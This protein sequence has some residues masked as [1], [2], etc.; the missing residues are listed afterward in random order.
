MLVDEL[1]T[2]EAEI[3][4]VEEIEELPQVVASCTVISPS[5]QCAN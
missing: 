4:E 3:F 5:R 2:L 1:E